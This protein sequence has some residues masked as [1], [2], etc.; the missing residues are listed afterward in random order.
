MSQL[1]ERF[2]DMHDAYAMGRR[3]C[4][5][6]LGKTGFQGVPIYEANDEV[7]LTFDDEPEERHNVDSRGYA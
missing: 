5:G 7:P 4:W 1:R 2:V 6:A 3:S